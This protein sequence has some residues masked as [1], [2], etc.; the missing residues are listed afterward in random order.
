MSTSSITTTRRVVVTG[1]VLH[2]DQPQSFSFVATT[3]GLTCFSLFAR[4]AAVSN[5]GGGCEF[6]ALGPRLVASTITPTG[7]L[8]KALLFVWVAATPDWPR[9]AGGA[10]PGPHRSFP[11]RVP[12]HGAAG[13][14]DH[15]EQ[16]LLKHGFRLRGLPCHDGRWRAHQGARVP[17]SDPA[18]SNPFVVL[19]C[20]SP[21]M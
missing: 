5:S 16:R 10:S 2:L 13:E 6:R 11:G 1:R 8:L 20:D 12:V 15:G 9:H 17:A 19:K 4:E 18:H 21:A 7:D 3:F 14:S